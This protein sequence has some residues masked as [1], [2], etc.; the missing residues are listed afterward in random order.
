LEDETFENVSSTAPIIRIKYHFDHPI[1]RRRGG[2]DEILIS[3]TLSL[4][5]PGAPLL[6]QKPVRILL[7]MG[8]TL[9][10][11]E[12]AVEEKVYLEGTFNILHG[13]FPTTLLSY[14][15]LLTPRNETIYNSCEPFHG[16]LHSTL[17]VD[18]YRGYKILTFNLFPVHYVPKLGIVY[19]FKEMEVT[20]LTKKA[21]GP[22]V[23]FR[24]SR[25]DEILV[26]ARVDNPQI[27]ATYNLLLTKS[28]RA[29]S[30]EYVIITN[31]S[32]KPAFQLLADRKNLTGMNPIAVT[33]EQIIVNLIGTPPKPCSTIPKLR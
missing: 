14:P 21:A 32:L 7:L 8:E 3:E 15:T 27:T 18:Y 11:L 19:Y 1:I 29:Y 13:Q 12:V 2:Y 31:E 30:Y 9:H 16:E 33:V 25:E 6:P 10:E 26:K 22:N 28:L 4:G 5:E 20:V 17:R 23:L 24:N